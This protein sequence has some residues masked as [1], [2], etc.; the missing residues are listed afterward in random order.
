MMRLRGRV[1]GVAS[2]F[3]SP[4]LR[5]DSLLWSYLG[6]RRLPQELSSFLVWRFFT[7]LGL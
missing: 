4:E 7:L 5:M 3:C 2:V 1:E 6:S